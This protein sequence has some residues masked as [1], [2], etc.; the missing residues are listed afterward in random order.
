MNV[1]LIHVRQM[2]SAS[3]HTV[4]IIALTLIIQIHHY[5]VSNLNKTYL[6]IWPYMLLSLLKA[7]CERL[8]S[9]IE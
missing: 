1:C 5:Q 7:Y 2:I 4:D 8:K 3:T 9:Q 6:L